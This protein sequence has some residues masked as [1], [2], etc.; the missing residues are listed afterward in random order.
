MVGGAGALYV[1]A[2]LAWTAVAY[3]ALDPR[4]LRETGSLI[5]WL[6]LLFS[7]LAVTALLPPIYLAI[8]RL[9]GIPNLARLCGNG[10]ILIASWLVQLSTWKLNYPERP[11]WPRVRSS[12]LVALIFLATMTALFVAAPVDGEEAADFTGR[13]AAEPAIRL[14]RAIFLS[15]MAFTAIE[16]IRLSWR[17]AGRTTRA[18]LP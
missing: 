6:I 10:S 8:D 4:R 15:Y 9:T 5:F 16:F 2:G 13:Y 11:L 3:K 12:G 17:Y 14:Y 18:M 1:A 7:A